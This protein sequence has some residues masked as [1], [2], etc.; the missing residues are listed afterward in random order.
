MACLLSHAQCDAEGFNRILAM[1]SFQTVPAHVPNGTKNP[2]L[3]R[4]TIARA[5]CRVAASLWAI[6]PPRRDTR[7]P[8]GRDS[9]NLTGSMSSI[10][11]RA[12]R[13]WAI[14]ILSP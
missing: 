7:N 6:L 3:G 14:E 10:G 2:F 13:E 11:T 8:G 4:L 5:R 9:T 12:S 1:R